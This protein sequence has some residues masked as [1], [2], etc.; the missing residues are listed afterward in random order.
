MQVGI[1]LKRTRTRN[2]T[3]HCAWLRSAVLFVDFERGLNISLTS[4][5]K[6][7]NGLPTRPWEFTHTRVQ[8]ST[9]QMEIIQSVLALCFHT[10]SCVR[11][12]HACVCVLTCVWKLCT[13]G[14][15]IDVGGS[16]QPPPTLF[17]EAVSLTAPRAQRSWLASQPACLCPPHPTP[18]WDC[19]WLLCPYS[20]DSNILF[21]RLHNKNRTVSNF[22]SNSFSSMI[23]IWNSA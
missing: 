19:R 11:C 3:T 6:G 20:V 5:L 22:L 21:S 15:H 1:E 2:Q 9:G 8:E 4:D 7:S 13:W 12:E 14:T 16:P 10:C 23:A 18:F 17:I